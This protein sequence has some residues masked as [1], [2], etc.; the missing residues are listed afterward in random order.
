MGNKINK[1]EEPPEIAIKF[2]NVVFVLGVLF[3][4][5]LVAFAIFKI[6]S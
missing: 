4:V 6:Y 3:S 2:A 1:F 5:I